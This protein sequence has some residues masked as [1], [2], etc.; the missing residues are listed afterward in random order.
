MMTVLTLLHLVGAFS[1]P[2]L[3]TGDANKKKKYQERFQNFL[4]KLSFN[5][6]TLFPTPHP[7]IPHHF[8]VTS[9]T[10]DIQLVQMKEMFI[11]I[12]TN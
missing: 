10:N 9:L 11:K 3:K 5:S 6:E 2:N 7:L 12:S 1:M 4:P 8:T